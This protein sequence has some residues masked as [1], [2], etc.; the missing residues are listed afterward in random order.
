MQLRAQANITL[1][2]LSWV[3]DVDWTRRTVNLNHGSSVEVRRNFF[4]EG[5]WNGEFSKGDF[6]ESDC[7]FEPAASSVMS[8]FDL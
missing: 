3:A 6:G 2:K 8:R 5:V 7:V 1:P 4:I